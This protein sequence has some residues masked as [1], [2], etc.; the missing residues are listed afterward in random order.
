[1]KRILC[2]FV[3][4]SLLLAGC[5]TLIATNCTLKL[6]P[7]EIWNLKLELMIPDSD[8]ALYGGEIAQSLSEQ[9][10]YAGD[11]NVEFTWEQLDRIGMETFPILLQ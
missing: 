4:M 11:E 9:E 2:G 10:Q 6:S 3:F 1:M 8:V 7:G 5:V